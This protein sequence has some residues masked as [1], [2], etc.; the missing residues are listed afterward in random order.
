MEKEK[1]ALLIRYIVCFCVAS[2]LVLGVFAIKGFFTDN[3][4][5]NMQLLHD[6]FFA[7]GALLMLFSA[8]LFLSAEG[9]LLGLT[10]VFGRAIK[11]LFIPFGRRDQESYAQYRER[12]LGGKKG[13]AGGA[14]FWTGLL[15]VAISVVFL[16]IW[17]QL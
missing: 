2:A 8:M 16:I 9:A 4:K 10:Y 11:A 14:V 7:S 5:Q 13:D 17:Y 12:K 1:K 3:A 6:A 15:F